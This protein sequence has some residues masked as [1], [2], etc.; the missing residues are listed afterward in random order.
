MRSLV[1]GGTRFIGLHLVSELLE[2]GHQVTVLNR[3]QTGGELPPAVERLYADRDDPEAVKRALGGREFDA[4]FDISAYTTRALAPAV[5]S[6]EGR[7]GRYVFCSTIAVYGLSET[8]PVLESQPLATDSRM[9]PPAQFAQYGLDKV[10]C[11][12]YLAERWRSRAFPSTVLRP[13][14]VYGPHNSAPLWELSF[15][16]RLRRGRPILVPGDGSTI[17]QF[18]FVDD[19]ALAFAAAP[20]T[21][22][23]LGQAYNMAGPEAVTITGYVRALG[24]VVGVE[25]EVILVPPNLTDEAGT[26]SS[27]PFGWGGSAIYSI[28][29]DDHPWDF[30]AE[31]ALLDHLRA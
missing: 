4:A 15:F 8:H 7:V 1:F 20:E 9:V 12:E 3:G 29:L 24:R 19:L 27:F 2:R 5:E 10:A 14:M 31:D 18:V 25:P 28:E 11:E 21:G 23:S 30:S 26:S 17:M 13:V 22:A 6:L 16:A